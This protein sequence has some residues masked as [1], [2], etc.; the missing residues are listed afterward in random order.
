MLSERKK[1]YEFFSKEGEE[2]EV[3]L[4]DEFLGGKLNISKLIIIAD[5]THIYSLKVIYECN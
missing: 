2:G 5:Q 4:S 1:N 3:Q